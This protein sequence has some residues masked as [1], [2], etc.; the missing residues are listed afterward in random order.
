MGGDD[1][2]IRVLLSFFNIFLFHPFSCNFGSSLQVNFIDFFRQDFISFGLV[3]KGF[4]D[5]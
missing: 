1:T 2:K 3:T 5:P 4:P